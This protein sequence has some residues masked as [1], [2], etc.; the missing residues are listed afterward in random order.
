MN[1]EQGDASPRPPR[2]PRYAGKYPRRFSQKYKELQGDPDTLERV[3]AAGKTPAGTH[4]P[5]MTAEVLAALAIQPG[6][7]VAD[8]TLGFGGHTAAFLEAGATVHAFEVDPLEG[9]L[10]LARLR[11]AGPAEEKLVFHPGNF[12]GMART[13]AAT[14]LS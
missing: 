2:R 4:R 5:I 13:L 6:D 10:T 11:A 14:G 3:A 8:A 9:P 7:T 1:T 12:A